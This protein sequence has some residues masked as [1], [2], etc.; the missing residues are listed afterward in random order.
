MITVTVEGKKAEKAKWSKHTMA[1]CFT[2]LWSVNNLGS[3]CQE[4]CNNRTTSDLIACSKRSL[5]FIFS[6]SFLVRTAPHYLN[7]WNRLVTL[8]L[9][10]VETESQS[11]AL[12][13]V[14][15]LSSSSFSE[16][17][18]SPETNF[19]P[20]PRAETHRRQN[21]DKSGHRLRETI[22]LTWERIVSEWHSSKILWIDLDG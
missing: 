11:D 21:M 8:S 13:R 2:T 12:D 20:E 7:A 10:E 6:R 1:A 16:S 9:S 4:M 14:F 15:G 22:M 3:P 17:S 5:P 18:W 19:I